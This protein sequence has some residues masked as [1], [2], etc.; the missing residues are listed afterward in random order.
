VT[1]V[2]LKYSSYIYYRKIKTFWTVYHKYIRLEINEGKIRDNSAIIGDNSVRIRDNLARN[3]DNLARIR[4]NSAISCKVKIER[5][6][7][8]SLKL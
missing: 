1:I 5:K 4:D 7:V 8:E 3:R 2:N 6:R